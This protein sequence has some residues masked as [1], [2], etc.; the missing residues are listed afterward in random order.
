MSWQSLRARRVEHRCLRALCPS[1]EGKEEGQVDTG[2][3]G[4]EFAD[5]GRAPGVTRVEL[6]L[7]NTD[8]TYGECVNGIAGTNRVTG[9]TSFPPQAQSTQI[10]RDSA[11]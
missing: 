8:Y 10:S 2:N 11:P 5:S 9:L 6:W 7:E 1:G 3:H 4:G